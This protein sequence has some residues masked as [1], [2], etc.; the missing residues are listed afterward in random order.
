[1]PS[2]KAKTYQK[3]D[4]EAIKRLI[5]ANENINFNSVSS[6]AG[7]SKATLYNNKDIRERIETLR[8]HQGQVVKREMNENNK[9]ALIKCLKKERS[10]NWRVKIL[11]IIYTLVQQSGQF[12]E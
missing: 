11:I 2:G 10:R 1:M 8:Q 9:D 4:D 6:E 3:V 12:V 5:R 7:V